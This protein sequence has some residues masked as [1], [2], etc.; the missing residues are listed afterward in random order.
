MNSSFILYIICQ[1]GIPCATFFPS[2]QVPAGLPVSSLPGM[3]WCL[4]QKK[5]LSSGTLLECHWCRRERGRHQ[6][7]SL[8]GYQ[9]SH[10]P[11]RIFHRQALLFASSPLRRLSC[12]CWSCLVFPP[13]AFDPICQR[14]FEKSITK[15]S[16]CFPPIMLFPRSATNPINCVS[17]DLSFQVLKPC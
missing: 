12:S 1:D 17:Q 10:L 14:L 4:L 8:G 13:A 6:G 15:I 7:Q 11:H 3:Q 9:M 16:V 2:L 5:I